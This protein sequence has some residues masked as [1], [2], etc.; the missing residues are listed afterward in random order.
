M[1]LRFSKWQGAGNDFVLIDDRSGAFPTEDL[2]LIKHVCDRHLGI[3][4]DGLILLQAGQ[5][6]RDFHMEFFNPDASQSFCGN[7]SRCAFAFWRELVGDDPRSVTGKH[8]SASF[9][10]IDGD[11]NAEVT[12]ELEVGIS[13]RPPR[14]PETISE[15]VDLLDTG[16]PHLLV[17]VQDPEKVSIIEEA[18]LHRDGP[19]FREAGVNVNFVQWDSSERLLRMRT[20]ERGVEAET[21]SCGTGVT[22][23]AL[24]AIHRGKAQ[25]NSVDVHTRG[26]RLR[27]EVEQVAEGKEP[28]RVMLIGPVM[29]VFTGTMNV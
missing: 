11:H 5:E 10:A 27:V 8:R 29:P 25:G 6:G 22:A 2:A 7:G 20:Y 3:G 12:G 28:D 4:S 16:S 18:H 17:W 1:E 21:L 9:S 14:K 24:D 23:A 19:R 26:G 15:F 13:M